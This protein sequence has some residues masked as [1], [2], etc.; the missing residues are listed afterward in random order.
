[1]TERPQREVRK[2]VRREATNLQTPVKEAIKVVQKVVKR[3]E[4]CNLLG[5]VD[6]GSP[7]QSK[8]FLKSN[9]LIP[10][11]MTGSG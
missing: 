4:A 6:A 1:V 5:E 9:S 8:L 7:S 11:K 2:E 10:T 3:N